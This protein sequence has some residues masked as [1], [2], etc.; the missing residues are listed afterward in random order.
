M[1]CAAT[2]YGWFRRWPDFAREV[3][4]ACDLRE[5]WLNLQMIEI[6]ERNGPFGLAA[7]KREAAPLQRAANRLAR[8]PGRSRRDPTR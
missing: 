1:P 4:F 6:C 5:E 7:T 3:G 2:L 8:R